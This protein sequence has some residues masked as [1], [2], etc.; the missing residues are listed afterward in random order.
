[1]ENLKV[2]NVVICVNLKNNNYPHFESVVKDLLDKNNN[3][4]ISLIKSYHNFIVVHH[5]KLKYIIFVQ[6]GHVNIIGTKRFEDIH[7]SLC[8]FSQFIGYTCT[9]C[10]VVNSTWTTK[11]QS[12]SSSSSLI[13]LYKLREKCFGG[14][15]EYRCSLRPSIFPA[16]VLRHHH[17]PT[18]ILFKNGTAN[19]LGAKS[20]SEVK[21]ALFNV[22]SK[23][24]FIEKSEIV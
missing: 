17:L 11:L 3:S 18:L 20:E 6:S 5:N 12:D 10:R 4:E 14:K 1:M 2:S 23:I 8:Q 15:N 22:V 13:D 19:I 24:E 21:Q 7:R 16:A 9:Q